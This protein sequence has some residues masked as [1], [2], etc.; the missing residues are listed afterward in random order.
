MQC[1]PVAIL[2]GL[3]GEGDLSRPNKRGGSPLWHLQAYISPPA[4]PSRQCFK[5]RSQVSLPL[6]GALAVI[7][8]KGCKGE[9]AGAVKRLAQGGACNP[10]PALISNP[11]TPIKTALVPAVP[12]AQSS[13]PLL[14]VII[15]EMTDLEIK[16]M[17]KSGFGGS[18]CTCKSTSWL[19]MQ[20]QEAGF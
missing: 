13:G 18:R 7:R 8:N 5:E 20:C 6:T 3:E 11:G 19:L 14:C 9:G 10:L 1:P 12:E 2:Q 4:F 17:H 16:E 15:R